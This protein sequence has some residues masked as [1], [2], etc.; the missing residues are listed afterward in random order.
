[1]NSTYSQGL[2]DGLIDYA[3]L[4]PPASL[5]LATVVANY[6]SYRQGP[7]RPLLGR[8]VVPAARVSEL[9]SYLPAGITSPWELSVLVGRDV[10]A[11]VATLRRAL[12]GR[13]D[14]VVTAL[15]A[16]AEE[17]TD[18]AVKV[19]EGWEVF[20]E[21]DHRQ[22]PRELIAAAAGHR[23]AV[24]IRT[25]GVVPDAIPQRSEVAR[26]LTA[27]R[28]QQV[29]FKATAG[30]HHPF[31]G[32]Y[33][34]TY[35]EGSDRAVMHGFVNVFFAAALLWHRRIDEAGVADL[36]AQSGS[37][38]WSEAAGRLDWQ[39]WSLGEAELAEARQHFARSFGSC[40]FTEPI[41]SL[42]R[43]GLL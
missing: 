11:G 23:R 34:L 37:P 3:G 29:A 19:D 31:P 38:T 33:A 8:L 27:C 28:D 1:M 26:F 32:S 5:D 4:F 6:A 21:I 20:Y 30:L 10:A 42:E 22:D 16:I 39:S 14:L 15:E 17:P 9:I 35:E 13:S 43:S 41:E 25:G 12:A 24:K 36:L 18:F 2:L 7:R 40:S